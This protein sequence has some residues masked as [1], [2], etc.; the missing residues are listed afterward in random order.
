MKFDDEK[1]GKI[2]E[3]INK[4]LQEKLDVGNIKIKGETY[5]LVKEED[6]MKLFENIAKTVEQYVK[7]YEKC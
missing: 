5:V 1:L 6:L 7:D 4:S 2:F 3:D